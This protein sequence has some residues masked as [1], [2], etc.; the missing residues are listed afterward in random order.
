MPPETNAPLEHATARTLAGFLAAL[1]LIAALLMFL[2]GI[3]EPLSLP[4]GETASAVVADPFALLS[5]EAD[6]AVVL[7]LLSDEVLYEKNPDAQLPLASLAK[8][9]LAIVVAESL[10]TTAIVRIGEYAESSTG[11]ES[12]SKGEYWSVQD[13][14]DFMLVT[15]SNGGARNL[16][17]A[18]DSAIR[19]RYPQ[20]PEGRATLW[21]MNALAKE[22]GLTQTYFLNVSGLDESET[23]SGAYGSARDMARLFAYGA[24]NYPDVFSRTAQ[25]AVRITP[26]R[27]ETR[28]IVYNT[29]DA[30]GRVPGLI[31]GKTG[32]TDLAGGNLAVVFDVGI[33]HPVVVVVLGSSRNGRFL[34]VT[35]LANAARE[36]ITAETL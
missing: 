29:N 3:D 12:L 19:Q 10:D 13:V 36:R 32:L 9:A 18:S 34:D 30:L 24:E 5:P 8:V 27:G 33:T 26:P 17:A 6:A 31:M 1:S 21:R 15:S 25:D 11:P 4:A 14:I 23:L 35:A 20:A 16:A 2:I 28:T 22:L 7:D